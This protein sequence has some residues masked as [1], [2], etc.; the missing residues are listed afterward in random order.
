MQSPDVNVLAAATADLPGH[1]FYHATYRKPYPACPSTFSNPFPSGSSCF[2]AHPVVSGQGRRGSNRNASRQASERSQF[3]PIGVPRAGYE[4][5]RANSSP[6][7]QAKSAVER[8]WS[9]S[10]FALL[11]PHGETVLARHLCPPPGRGRDP[12]WPGRNATQRHPA[13]DGL[14][15]ALV[16][17]LG[18]NVNLS[19][20]PACDATAHRGY[21]LA[22]I[23]AASWHIE[24][25]VRLPKVDGFRVGLNFRFL[26]TSRHRTNPNVAMAPAHVSNASAWAIVSSIMQ[27]SPSR[28]PLVR[29]AV[30]AVHL[31]PLPSL[32]KPNPTLPRERATKHAAAG[33]ALVH[34]PILVF[35]PDLEHQALRAA[36]AIRRRTHHPAWQAHVRDGKTYRD[37]AGRSMGRDGSFDPEGPSQR[38][39]PLA[40]GSRASG[41][42][43]RPRPSAAP[44]SG[45]TG[46]PRWS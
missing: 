10:I 3:A 2:P 24:A 46:G 40:A 14:A 5:G 29:L 41:A 9:I 25:S 36:C 7:S 30:R 37:S 35:A 34:R 11:A 1:G 19:A 38:P 42:A 15:N 16:D 21:G 17:G 8:W 22:H 27:P 12:G 39:I 33:R 26:Y 20:P 18:R 4:Q 23:R 43:F 45:C 44:R 28:L 6:T 31:P 32:P 13:R